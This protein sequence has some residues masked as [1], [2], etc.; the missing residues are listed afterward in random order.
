MLKKFFSNRLSY[1]G[2]ILLLVGGLFGSVLFDLQVVQGDS[3]R[4]QADAS[5]VY[6]MDVSAARGEIVDRNGVA[7]ATNRVGY[8]VQFNKLFLPSEDLNETILK[9]CGIMTAKGQTWNDTLPIS[10]SEPYGFL[11]SAE[12]AANAGSTEN[13]DV[14]TEK[15]LADRKSVV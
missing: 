9:L 8:N 5:A 6:T 15:E 4:E 13:V 10:K 12:E 1:L 11:T 3:Y 14:R 2:L 7:L